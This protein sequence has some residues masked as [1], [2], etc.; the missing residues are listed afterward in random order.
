MTPEE[1]E[2]AW[3]S[4]TQWLAQK[5]LVTYSN[6]FLPSQWQRHCW[7]EGDYAEAER[8]LTLNIGVAEVLSVGFLRFIQEWLRRNGGAWRVAIPMDKAENFVMIYP[9]AIKINPAAEQDLEAFVRAARPEL[10]RIIRE[11]PFG[12]KFFGLGDKPYPP[13]P[14]EHQSE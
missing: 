2:P 5:Y 1:W 10:E 6:A 8:T 12:K 11:G 4:L 3:E 14:E 13:L 9:E 7:V